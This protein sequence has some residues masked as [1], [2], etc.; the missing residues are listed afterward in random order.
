ME[1]LRRKEPAS[2][3]SVLDDG[4]PPADEQ[5]GIT[6]NDDIKDLAQVTLVIYEEL[7]EMQTQ[8]CNV[9]V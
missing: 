9:D 2:D 7:V 1:A 3:T 4:A 8:L 6:N 5:L